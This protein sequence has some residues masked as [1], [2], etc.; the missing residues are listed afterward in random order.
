MTSIPKAV[1]YYSP[2]SV[3]SAVARL[4]I[5]EK[6]YGEDELDFRT[7][8]LHKGQNYD[9]AFLRLNAKA[10]VPTLLVPYE[11]TLSGDGDSRY[12][13]LTD[14]KSIV[15]FLD[16]SRSAISRTHTTSSAP[17]PTLTPATIAT[18][19]ICK[20]IIDEILHSEVANPNTLLFV[21]AY[22]DASLQTLAAEQL[23]GLKQ[24]QQALAGY[25]SEAEGGQVRVSDKVKKLWTEKLEATTVIIAVLDDARK[26][27]TELDDDGK[28]NRTAFF[29]AAHRAW[30]V[31]LTEVLTQLSKE[32]VGPYTLGEQ[33]SIA[34]LHL[35]GWLARVGKLAGVTRQ[36]DGETMVKKLE[37]R[38]GGGFRLVRDFRN[39]RGGVEKGAETKLGAFWD[40][41]GERDSWKKVY[42]EGL[43]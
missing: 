22:D 13:A 6:G 23:P 39:E 19:T 12:K 25:L 3:W 32:M 33:F 20:V 14:T 27:E 36:D 24:R 4:A 31:N 29:K 10:T 5:E 7:V 40:A 42:S 37:G 9:L 16:K 18:S 43:Y 35:A 11:D 8:D 15:E 34:D 17:A 38:V 41:V 30:E 26:A 2:I 1:L 28:A 21:N